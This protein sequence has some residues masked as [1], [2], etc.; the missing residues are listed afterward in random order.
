MDRLTA[1]DAGFL[2]QERGGAHLHVGAVL[3]CD[4][5]PPSQADMMAHLESRLDVVPRYRQRLARP[6]LRLGKPYWV[7]DPGF[8]LSYH[9]RHTALPAP[10]GQEELR[11]LTGRIFAQRL[12]RTKPLWEMWVVEGL[13]EGR[14]A[15]I[16]KTHHSVVDGVS[17][18]DLMTAIFDIDPSPPPPA[19]GGQDSWS[20]PPPPT[21]VELA[22]HVARD[23][24]VT[25]VRLFQQAGSLA[26]TPG[27]ALS[28]ARRIIGGLGEIVAVMGTRA[29]HTA[30]NGPIGPHRDIAW[31][32][33]DLEDLKAIKN[34]L[35]GTVNDVFL[36]VMAGAIRRWLRTHGELVDGLRLR[37]CVPVSVRTEADRGALGNRIVAMFAPLPVGIE[38]PV[39]R[40]HE[41][42]RAMAGLKESGQAV[43]ADAIAAVEEFAPPTIL[44]QASRLQF[45]TR[46]YNVLL[47]NVPGPQF[48]VFVLGR[49][50]RSFIPV[51]FLSEDKRLAVAIVSY[52]GRAVISIIAD[53]DH[54][55][56]LQELMG[57]VSGS[58]AELAA[59]ARDARPRRARRRRVS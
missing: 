55:H 19:D 43:G 31:I 51:A 39:E 37:A 14:F 22:A 34:G 27:R 57:E 3:I 10:G 53:S 18:I 2:D 56:D 23:V 20:A 5:P 11:R 54:V 29:T 38:D 12:D 24:A 32:E 42:T 28:D 45:S 44:A 46:L 58:V 16:N 40:L 47:S 52:N 6:P 8:N 9:V 49:E 41:V 30:L 26:A 50:L 15:L 33:L 17:G 7:D 35:G 4:G 48:P 59:A 25:P 13:D 36:A 21:A 1:V